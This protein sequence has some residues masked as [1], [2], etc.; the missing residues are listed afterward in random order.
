[1]SR[2]ND[3]G[4]TTPIWQVGPDAAD[5]SA[6]DMPPLEGD[7]S[8]DV[9]VIGAGMAGL[10]TAYLLA[11]A[12]KDVVVLDDNAP[13]GGE[14]IR[15]TGHLN[16]YIDDGLSEVEKVHGEAKM[17]LAVRSHGDAIDLIEQICRDLGVDAH[18][19]R[20]D[21][22]LFVAPGG[23][24]QD[25]LDKEHDAANRAGL[26]GVRFADGAPGMGGFETGRCLVVGGQATFHAGRYFAALAG[27]VQ[28]HGGR[29]RRGHVGDTL[30]GTEVKTDDGK[31][32]SCGWTCTCTNTPINPALADLPVIHAR[33]APYRTY[34]V[35]LRLPEDDVPAVMYSDTLDAYHYVRPA[36]DGDGPVLDRRRRGPQDRPRSRHRGRPAGLAGKVGEGALAAGR[37]A[38]GG[39]ERAGDGAARL[40][41]LHRPQTSATTTPPSSPPATAAWA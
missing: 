5:G 8:C 10:T 4:T 25:Y 28:K 12:G 37:R 19:E 30:S 24:G 31:T 16:S 18:F 17:K 13:A 14:S 6:V 1:M 41:R 23:E 33:Q 9:C 7:L 39:V 34:V 15:T 3:D 36:R 27:A 20:R 21:E 35:A 29:L 22:V 40:P 2:A 32:I 11:K 26:P 38:G